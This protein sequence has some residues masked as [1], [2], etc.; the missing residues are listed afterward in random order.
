MNI[1]SFVAHAHIHTRIHLS[2]KALPLSGLAKSGEQAT[3][4]RPDDAVDASG[5]SPG[6][7]KT[8]DGSLYRLGLPL[9]G[10]GVDIRRV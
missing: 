6:S 7:E 2:P 4:V 1:K 5:R 3:G 10:L 8:D 9:K